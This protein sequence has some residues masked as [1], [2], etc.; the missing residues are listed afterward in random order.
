MNGMNVLYGPNLGKFQN[1]SFSQPGR[2]M[3]LNM[4]NLKD[5]DLTKIKG[6]I[7]FNE[8]DKVILESMKYKA[9][10]LYTDKIKLKI[11]D[12]SQAKEKT[13]IEGMYFDQSD[14]FRNG[15]INFLGNHFKSKFQRI[16]NSSYVEGKKFW[17]RNSKTPS[18]L[19]HS[20]I[21]SDN[22]ASFLVDKSYY[23]LDDD[24]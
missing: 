1:K 15:R 16:D 20:V 3:K 7:P 5:N 21:Q 23:P 18:K 19:S 12:R 8:Q 10:C 22:N 9:S 17:S 13:N 24:F 4:L 6:T 14:E 11:F 2:C